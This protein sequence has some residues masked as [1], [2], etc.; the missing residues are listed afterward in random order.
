M[1]GEDAM[2]H[3]AHDHAD[4]GTDLPSEDGLAALAELS[5]TPATG[6]K[7]SNAPGPSPIPSQQ[8]AANNHASVHGC[9]VAASNDSDSA[10]AAAAAAGRGFAEAAAMAASNTNGTAGMASKSG[11]AADG[12]CAMYAAPACEQGGAVPSSPLA[13]PPGTASSQMSPYMEGTKVLNCT[14]AGS[15]ASPLPAAG[16]STCSTTTPLPLDAN[17]NLPL[18]W[19]DMYENAD[20]RPGEVT[21]L[22]KVLSEGQW[23]S[24]AVVL[25]GLHRSLLVV[26]KQDV[27]D[28]GDGRIAALEAAAEADPSQKIE[29][30]KH[31]QVSESG[32]LLAM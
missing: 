27:F 11:T 16:G 13:A 18:Y 29:L 22:G 20:V 1:H 15:T 6:F 28:D 3:D 24:A 32:C 4:C 26:P 21:L 30:I 5:R 7:P 12:W 2:M 23:V 10:A 25:R 9:A 31:L 14:A 19:L 17:G 8:N